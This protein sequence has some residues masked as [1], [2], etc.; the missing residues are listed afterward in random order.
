MRRRMAADERL[1]GPVG[2][3]Q[4]FE[5]GIAR[6]PV[7]SMQTGA[8]NL[9]DRV[10]TR[11]AGRAIHVGLDPPALI[12]RRWNHWNRLLRHVDPITK[13]GLVYVREALLQELS[14][15]MGNVE[16]NALRPG[17]FHLSVDRPG[18]D[19]AWRERPSPV[20]LR[21]KVFA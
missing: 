19:I 5:Q 10:Q 18:D 9:S 20:D 7:R 4:P 11:Q 13:A 6:Q 3:Y 12:M 16:V 15:L 14:R 1:T 8:G 2:E 17:T 21:N